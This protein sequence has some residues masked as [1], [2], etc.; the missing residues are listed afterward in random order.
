[1]ELLAFLNPTFVLLLTG[2]T[3]LGIIFGVIPGL[4]ATMAVAVCLP[5][6]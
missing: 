3:M 1:M 6:T 4:T 5:L 2:G